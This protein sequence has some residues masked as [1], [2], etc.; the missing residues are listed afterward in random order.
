MKL[1]T[2]FKKLITSV[3]FDFK[4][5]DLTAFYNKQ[6]RLVRCMNNQRLRVNFF[7]YM[8][9]LKLDDL[10][11]LK[12][13]LG[14]LVAENH[15][16]ANT[17]QQFN[18]SMMLTTSFSA[19]NNN[20]MR[21]N[22]TNAYSK[23]Q[24]ALLSSTM[25]PMQQQKSMQTALNL[26]SISSQQSNL[27]SDDF[28]NESQYSA[29]IQL[30]NQ[31]LIAS[32]TKF[33]TELEN[34]EADEH[35]PRLKR[36]ISVQFVENSDTYIDFNRKLDDYCQKNA[37]SASRLSKLNSLFKLVQQSIEYLYDKDD[38]KSTCSFA[39]PHQSA[40]NLNKLNIRMVK[41]LHE[42]LE[43]LTERTVELE[44][45]FVSKVFKKLHNYKARQ[46]SDGFYELRRNFFLYFFNTPNRVD[47][48]IDELNQI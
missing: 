29:F 27:I 6:D 38:E 21:A 36:P 5:I 26:S 42:S 13:T 44:N 14:E 16:M 39:M 48:I 22:T 9:K 45:S 28:I 47:A 33:H 17:N 10:D 24:K 19:V 23:Q 18:N 1:K 25:A 31:F 2:L 41:S 8:Q 7:A 15:S 20:V 40:F 46:A 4:K 30:I 37:S 11:Y 35:L 32:L 12:Q 34:D 3:A 43:A